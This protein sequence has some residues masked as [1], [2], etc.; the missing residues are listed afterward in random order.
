MIVLIQRSLSYQPY[1]N[2]LS[3]NIENQIIFLKIVTRRNQ[4][5]ENEEYDIGMEDYGGF[6]DFDDE[7][8]LFQD[9]DE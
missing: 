1:D 6:Y 5:L 2:D 9:R 7:T 3:Y 8:C 4:A